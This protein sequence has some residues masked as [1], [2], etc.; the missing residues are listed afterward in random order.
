LR[1]F[2]VDSVSVQRAAKIAGWLLLAVIA[3]FSLSPASYRPVT[4]LGHNPE[5]FLAHVLLGLA[6]GIGY[7]ERWRL[8]ALG[9]VT[10]TG[11]IEVAQ[12]LVP[13][14]H[15]RLRDF[16]IDASAAC[17]GLGLAWIG[18]IVTTALS[19]ASQSRS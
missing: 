4:Q 8:A 19:R 14:R 1:L 6:F 10:L 16:L 9:L 7:A 5:H 2:N 12:L 11:A 17:L 3:F 18:R 15:A 13:G